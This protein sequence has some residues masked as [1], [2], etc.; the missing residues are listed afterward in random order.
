MQLTQVKSSL[1]VDVDV[2]VLTAHASAYF[3]CIQFTVSISEVWLRVGSLSSAF[4]TVDHQTLLSVQAAG[5]LR[6]HRLGAQ[7]V[8]VIFDC[9]LQCAAR[10]VIG[11]KV[12]HCL[13]RRAR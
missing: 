3:R 9:Q 7:L 6:C 11:P 10:L 2:K 12:V 1:H 4:D 5:T 13:H 8:P